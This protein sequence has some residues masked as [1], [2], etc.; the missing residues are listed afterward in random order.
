MGAS[1]TVNTKAEIDSALAAENVLEQV[2]SALSHDVR[3]PLRQMNHFLEFFEREMPEIPDSAREH[4]DFV[5]SG[6]EHAAGMVETLVQFARLERNSGDRVEIRLAD[7]LVEAMRRTRTSLDAPDVSLSVSGTADIFGCEAQ[8]MSLFMHIFENSVM[9]CPDTRT[10]QISITLS[11][12]DRHHVQVLIED[13][14][15]GLKGSE[16]AAFR[17]FQKGLTVGEEQ[18]LG[19][20][21]AF[22]RR[23]AEIHGGSMQLSPEPGSMGGAVFLVT[24]PELHSDK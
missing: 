4:L 23:Y 6:L 19:T 10:P 16:A 24:L 8:I 14:G 21:L 17:L 11:H 15:D 20:G 7:L 2:A 1:M 9:F 3:T 5:K 18:G 13:N 12:P 22:A